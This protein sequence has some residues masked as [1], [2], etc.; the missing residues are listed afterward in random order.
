MK[1]LSE[2]YKDTPAEYGEEF[3]KDLDKIMA[4]S[5]IKIASIIWEV[6]FLDHGRANMKHY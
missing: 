3:T 6:S 1:S 5:T 2:D 4:T